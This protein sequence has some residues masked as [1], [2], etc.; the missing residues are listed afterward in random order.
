MASQSADLH[1]AAILALAGTA[2]SLSRTEIARR[3]ELSPA[4]VTQ[5]TK[6][7]IERGLLEIG[8][9]HV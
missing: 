5:L 9:A 6:D 3:L 1:R 4:S 8:R 7:L 2:G